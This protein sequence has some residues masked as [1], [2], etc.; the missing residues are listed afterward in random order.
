MA[1]QAEAKTERGAIR[2]PSGL[3]G[4]MAVALLD[5]RF[6]RVISGDE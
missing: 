6:A 5:L 2:A 3:A 1:G 4:G